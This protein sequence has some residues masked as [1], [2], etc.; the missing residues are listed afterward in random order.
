MMLTINKNRQGSMGEFTAVAK[1]S[2]CAV[3][4]DSLI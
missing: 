4:E 3:F 1:L 2:C